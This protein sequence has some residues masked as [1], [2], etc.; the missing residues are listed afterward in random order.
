MLVV[1]GCDIDAHVKIHE[2][3]IKR[4]CMIK[5]AKAVKNACHDMVYYGLDKTVFVRCVCYCVTCEGT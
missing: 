1:L 2:L 4:K 5:E 3:S